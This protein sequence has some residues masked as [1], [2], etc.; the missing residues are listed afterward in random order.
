MLASG[1]HLLIPLCTIDAVMH[2]IAYWGNGMSVVYRIEVCI[3]NRVNQCRF[4]RYGGKDRQ[5][6]CGVA[7]CVSL[8]NQSLTIDSGT[9][10]ADVYD[11]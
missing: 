11:K 9:A 3:F 8:S 10:H 6:N 5:R 1:P 7:Y 2:I 4:A